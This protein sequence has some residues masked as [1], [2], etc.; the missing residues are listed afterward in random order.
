MNTTGLYYEDVVL[1]E[2]RESATRPV[3][4]ADIRAFCEL[5][6]DF[7]PLH[8]DAAY[9]QSRGFPG[10][11]AHGLYG[12]ALMEG[13]KTS[14]K[15][16]ENTSIASLGWD[17]VRF[18]LP[19]LAGDVVHVVFRVTGKRLSSRAGRGVLTEDVRLV[20]QRGEIVIQAQHAALVLTR[21]PAGS[22]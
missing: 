8:T 20:N 10:L 13:L 14:L 21:G 18:L 17:Q 11:I 22:D 5:T 3:T 7:H 2:D 1:D 19:L 12:L 4:P 9:A 6:E 15:L 16:Y